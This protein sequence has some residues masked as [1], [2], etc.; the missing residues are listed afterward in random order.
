MTKPV[1]W[2]PSADEA[3]SRIDGRLFASTTEAAVILDVDPRTLRAALDRGEVPGCRAG[4]TWR[5]PVSWL[6][7]QA[8]INAA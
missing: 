1:T 2:I 6:R 7:E 3:L 4:T 8:R 5:I